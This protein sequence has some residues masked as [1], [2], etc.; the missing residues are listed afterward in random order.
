MNELS[1]LSALRGAP[2]RTLREV[3]EATG[4]SWR[5]TNVV[6]EEL[7]GHGWL[8]EV[9]EQ[10]SGRRLGRPARRFR[11]R[12][13]AGHVLGLDIGA[14]KILAV[15]TDLEGNPA[16]HHRADARPGDTAPERLD[17]ARTAIA[18]ALADAGLGRDDLWAAAVGTAGIITS[19]GRVE[20]SVVLPGWTG[21]AL[22]EELSR[23]LPCPIAVENDCSLAAVAERWRGH[24][25][26]TTNM[27]YVLSGLRLGAGLIINGGLHRG[28]GGA[29]GEIGAL[30]EFGWSDA[31]QRLAEA[32]GL[33]EDT[34]REGAAKA[35]FDAARTGDTA[36]LEAVD[37]FSRDLA[38]GI[39]AMAL[40]VDPEL[41]VLGGGFSRAHDLLLPRL[42]EHLAEL[43]VRAPRLEASDLGDQAVAL[44]AVRVALDAIEHHMTTLETSTPL[45][46]EP[47]RL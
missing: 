4:L 11:F 13:E 38:R 24:A 43:C 6:A 15:V 44:G 37:S 9:A 19:E 21:L 28:H 45:L 40:T 20:K 12:A 18:A 41:V 30:A 2:A 7:A 42:D 36:S 31:P 17:T 34:P 25:A 14:H 29:A 33:P 27:I 8:T 5:T 22:A 23:G 10:R 1:V 26:A 16:G 3:S 46:P 47:L 32:A 39:A 35:V